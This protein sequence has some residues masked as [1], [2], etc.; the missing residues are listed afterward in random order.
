MKAKSKNNPSPEDEL[1]RL[2]KRI[3]ELE[4]AETVHKQLEHEFEK[5]FNFSLDLIAVGDYNGYLK[6]VN[7]SFEKLLGYTKEEL[8]SNHYSSFVHPDDRDY[9]TNETENT[10]Y[11]GKLLQQFQN[12]WIGKDGTGHWIDW[13]ALP[14]QIDE[15]VFMIGRDIT[16][17]K[18]AEVALRISEE[19]Y[20][21]LVSNIPGAIYIGDADWTIT[22]AS[23]AFE[24]IIGYPVS[25]IINNNKRTYASIVYPDDLKYLEDEI[26][27]AYKEKRNNL[28]LEYRIIHQK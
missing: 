21:A 28:I 6:R 27:K 19:H 24:D 7:S 1:T 8:L 23:P 25:D 18:Q 13:M 10:L 20:R 26:S 14:D 11:Q 9:S 5:M 15:E 16:E 2:R 3:A 17:R 12:R 22:F 4:A